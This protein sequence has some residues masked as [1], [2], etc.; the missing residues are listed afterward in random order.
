MKPMTKKIVVT[1]VVLAAIV[2]GAVIYYRTRGPKP[3]SEDLAVPVYPGA[4]TDTDTFATRLSPR[5]RAKLIKA[6]IYRTDDSPDKVIKFYKEKLNKEKTQVIETS[7]RGVPGAVFR[8]DVDGTPRIVIIENNEDTKKTE[9][10]ISSIAL[11]K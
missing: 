9:I 5:D 11:P 7:R 2:A 6:F 10:T 4:T 1:L 3:I 8:T